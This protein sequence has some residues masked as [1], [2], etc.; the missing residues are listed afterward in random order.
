MRQRKAFEIGVESWPAS[1]DSCAGSPIARY[2][3]LRYAA[4]DEW[5]ADS[6]RT[7]QP[8]LNLNAS[9]LLFT[10]L[11][12]DSRENIFAEPAGLCRLKVHTPGPIYRE[13]RI[14]RDQR[15]LE[16]VPGFV[17]DGNSPNR[18]L[19]DRNVL[20]R[21]RPLVR[22]V[23]ARVDAERI[24]IGRARVLQTSRPAL[25][26]EMGAKLSGSADLWIV[27]GE[28]EANM[29]LTLKWTKAGAG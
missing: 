23:I 25:T 12:F 1:P 13:R 21:R 5:V 28:A 2:R 15:R 24:V 29:K 27:K 19:C 11:A 10:F 16:R 4:G 8:Q 17:A 7:H 26:L 6:G 9:G 18:E 20:G 14:D 3:L 22:R